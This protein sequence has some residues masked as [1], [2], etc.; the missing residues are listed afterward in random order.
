MTGRDW[1]PGDDLVGNGERG[2]VTADPTGEV[3]P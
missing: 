2:I 1:R 3:R